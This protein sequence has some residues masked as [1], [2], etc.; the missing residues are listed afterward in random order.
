MS[1]NSNSNNSNSNNSNSPPSIP[2]QEE[3]EEE[4]I[5]IYLEFDDFDDS[6]VISSSKN[7]SISNLN[8]ENVTCKVITNSNSN[9]SNSNCGELL[10]SGEHQIN[11]GT[12]H[13]YNKSKRIR[14]EE[15]E[16]DIQFIGNTIKKT[17]FRL[18]KFTSK[19]SQDT[20]N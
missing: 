15:S 11:L 20:S 3:E 17:K 7:I 10:F 13:F 5:L 19:L 8:E 16:E 14:T 1:N 6:S 12:C 9:S 18:I 2:Q 4:E